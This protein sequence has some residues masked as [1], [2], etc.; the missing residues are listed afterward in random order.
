MTRLLRT[1]TTT[2]TLAMVSSMA[3][4]DP[5]ADFY[6]GRTINFYIGNT[7]GGGYDLY[8]RFIAMHL[9]RYIPGT[10]SIV[11]VNMP[12]AGGLNMAGWM[13]RQAPRDGT[14]IAIASQVLP[15]EQALGSRAAQ[16]DARKFVWLGR[17]AP[18]VEVSYTWH[19][20]KTRTLADARLRETV[21]GGVSPTSNTVIYLRLLN[22]L[23]GTKFKIISGYPGTTETHLAME[24]GET[25]GATKTWE[26]FKADNSDWL[27]DKKVNMLVQY[28]L[29]KSPELPDVPLMSDLG[30]T[31]ADRQVLRFFNSGNELGRAF[32]TAPGVPP[33]RAAALRKALLDMLKD[34][35]FLAEAKKRKLQINALAGADVQTLVEGI[36][37]VSPE[38]IE[39][40]KKARAG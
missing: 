13:F 37:R 14:A 18:V 24:R 6:R 19:T 8:G 28:A 9:G 30:R 23:A 7:P 3:A 27:R 29:K 15:I 32:M 1:V 2:M 25:E 11:P 33:E 4:A 22:A 16:Y 31:E 5:V 26:A 20:S 34:A 21:M 12:G 17:A 10:P 39:A 36:L 38:L 35:A 40:A